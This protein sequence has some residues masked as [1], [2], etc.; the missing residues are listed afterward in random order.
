[1]YYM[2]HLA[3]VQCLENADD[4]G[5]LEMHVFLMQLPRVFDMPHPAILLKNHPI[6]LKYIPACLTVRYKLSLVFR[7]QVHT[8]LLPKL[9]M[10]SKQRDFLS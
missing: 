5:S 8:T 1:M 6:S 7:S 9:C 4:L 10:S 2:L 3:I